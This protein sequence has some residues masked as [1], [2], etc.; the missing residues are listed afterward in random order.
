MK[1]EVRKDGFVIVCDFKIGEVG[2]EEEW[3]RAEKDAEPEGRRYCCKKTFSGF[4]RVK[5]GG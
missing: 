1:A 4:F 3:V 5:S 2:V